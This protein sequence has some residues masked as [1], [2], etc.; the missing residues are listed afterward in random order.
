MQKPKK[1]HH[2]VPAFYLNGFTDSLNFDLVWIYQ[3]ENDTIFCD[4]PKNIGFI[5]H[6]HTFTNGDGKKDSETIEN[7]LNKTWESPSSNIIKEI[8]E[9]K[10]PENEQRDLFASFLGISLTRVPSYK[11]NIE[12]VVAHTA[13]ELEKQ[14][15]STPERFIKSL[16]DYKN[17]TGVDLT[18]EAEDLRNFILSGEFDID[19]NPK[20]FLSMFMLH[21][22]KLGKIISQMNWVFVE[23]TERFKFITSDNPV[24]QIDPTY[25]PNSLYSSISGL[26]NKYVELTFPISSELALFASWDNNRKECFMP[27]NNNLIKDFNKRAVMS[28]RRFVYASEKKEGTSKL[29]KKYSKFFIDLK[30][31]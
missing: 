31:N 29:I 21:G 10:F 28:A 19:V 20:L 5:K 30:I 15:A 8:R 26:G 11:Q 3:K 22:H 18:D 14:I 13:L 4:K 23:A 6:Y 17:S 27:G 24:F 12:K 2:Y 1:K 16:E 7:I 25:N 9:G